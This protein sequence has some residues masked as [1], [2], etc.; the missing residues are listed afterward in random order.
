MSD[1]RL[2][3]EEKEVLESY[4]SG[5]W[6]AVDDVAVAAECYQDYARATN[7]K[8]R[9][10]NVRISTRDLVGIQRRALEEGIPYQTLISSILHK[11]VSGRL[12]DRT[13]EV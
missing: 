7:R 8:D 5:E 6:R 13:S 4:E 11:Y 3:R 9:R 2:D 12:T 10:V 1:L